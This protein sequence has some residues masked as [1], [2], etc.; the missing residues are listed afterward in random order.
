MLY[1]NATD[2]IAAAGI[3][4]LSFD[5]LKRMDPATIRSL[6]RIWFGQGRWDYGRRVDGRVA[7]H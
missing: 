5:L 3:S 7:Y 4:S 2:T 6:L 1:I